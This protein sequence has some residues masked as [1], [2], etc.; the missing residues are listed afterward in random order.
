MGANADERLLKRRLN[1]LDEQI[2]KI[3]RELDRIRSKQKNK[4]RGRKQVDRVQDR[5]RELNDM[6]LEV[7][8]EQAVKQEKEKKVKVQE[9]IGE[10]HVCKK[11]ECGSTKVSE[12]IA[13]A[14]IIIV[15]DTCG[16]RYTV[17]NEQEA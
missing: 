11:P 12:V 2:K 5:E 16:S 7:D 6:L 9:K 14:F 8:E 4:G 17:R 3:R 15:C 10:V 13:G 1:E